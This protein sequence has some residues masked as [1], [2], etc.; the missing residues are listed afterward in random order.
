MHEWV[1]MDCSSRKKLIKT[2]LWFCLQI[3]WLETVPVKSQ[4]QKGSSHFALNLYGLDVCIEA[5]YLKFSLYSVEQ[6]MHLWGTSHPIEGIQDIRWITTKHNSFFP[7]T[8]KGIEKTSSSA[9]VFIDNVF[10]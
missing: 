1:L 2:R 10:V 3:K 9:H 8:V 4:Q 6:I 5:I 7:L